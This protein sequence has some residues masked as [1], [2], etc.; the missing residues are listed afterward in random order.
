M[1]RYLSLSLVLFV[2]GLFGCGNNGSGF[3][4]DG[5]GVDGNVDGSPF[6]G[7][8]GFGDTG[9]AE[10]SGCG[11]GLQCQQT[12]GTTPISGKVS[13]PADVNGLYNVYVYVPNDAL[14]PITDGPT[15]TQ[16]QAPASG[17]PVA[18]A[19][20]D[21]DGNFSIPNAP[22]GSNIPLVLQLGKWRRHLTIPT[23]TA[24]VGTIRKRDKFA[25]SC[26]KSS[27]RLRR[28]TTSR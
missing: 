21:A 27:T 23:V 14:A 6:D 24:C 5:G 8:F 18:S 7:G 28:T 15:C 19:S 1:H 17:N 13:D 2:V 3:G 22:I 26:R 20:T 11:V 9:T 25:A 16:C 12:C 4:G 10:A